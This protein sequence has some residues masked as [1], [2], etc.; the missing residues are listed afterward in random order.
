MPKVGKPPFGNPLPLPPV[1]GKGERQGVQNK[2]F[3]LVLFL[4]YFKQF[5]LLKWL[6]MA[7]GR[8]SIKSGKKGKALPHFNYICGIGKYKNKTDEIL[9]VEHKNLPTW[10]KNNPSFFWKSADD[11]ER[12]NGSTYREHIISLPRE[13][14][15]EQNLKFVHDWINQ[16]FGDKYAYSLSYHQAKASDGDIQPH[17]HLMFCERINDGIERT[18]EQ[19]F[20]RYN[21][22]NPHKG[23]AKKDNTG[24]KQSERQKQLKAQRERF[25]ELL[26]RHLLKNGFNKRIDMRNYKEKGLK[27]V[28]TNLSMGEFNL[29]KKIK[30]YEQKLKEDTQEFEKNKIEEYKQVKELFK[31]VEFELQKR[32]EKAR[33]YIIDKEQFIM[34]F[35]YKC[36]TTRPANWS[37]MLDN[38]AEN[39]RNDEVHSYAQE[40]EVIYY[41]AV[42]L[43]QEER[44]REKEREDENNYCDKEFEL[45]DEKQKLTLEYLDY[46]KR[47]DE[48]FDKKQKIEEITLENWESD[49]KIY[50]K[51]DMRS[52]LFFEN[53]IIYNTTQSQ[54]EDDKDELERE[55]QECLERERLERQQQ[56]LERQR[57]AQ[58]QAPRPKFRP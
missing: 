10:A 15:K 7:I 31:K 50:R 20:K 43:R 14:S 37:A 33:K 5:F 30:K 39:F 22:K 57:Q 36:L 29:I 17:I 46:T 2:F 52:R 58:Q 8:I 53:N 26:E 27:E 35:E 41:K 18:A 49:G 19:Y 23:G 54:K 32:H 51:E 6:T 45:I 13:L 56:E 47:F 1:G 3:E 28:P 12:V 4:L 40:A 42:D 9:Y 34:N 16:E 11:F 55:Q 21:S 48:F 38:I 24:I 44:R 25:G